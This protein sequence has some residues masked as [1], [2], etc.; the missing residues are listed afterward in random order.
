MPK[1]R[2]SGQEWALDLFIAALGIDALMP[3][4]SKLQAS[5]VYGMNNADV[6]R[7]VKRTKGLLGMRE[8]YLRVAR[9][10]EAI[11]CEAEGAG[12]RA[13]ARRHFHQAALAYGMAQYTIQ[14]DF[15]KLKAELHAKSQECYLKAAS[16]ADTPVEK[17]EIPFRDN[18]PF[19]G[20]SFPGIL[21]LPGGEGPFPCVIFIPGTDMHKE[22]IPNLEDNLFLKRGLACLSIDGPGQGES[23]L[24][25]L[26][27]N[28]LTNNYERAVSAAIDY[29][30]GRGEIDARHIA[31]LGVSTGSYWEASAAVWESRRKG[32]IKAAVGLMP[33]WNPGFEI[34]MKY[35]QPN[36]KSNY[37]FM[38]GFKDEDEFDRHL[39]VHDLTD[40]IADVKCPLLLCQG[41]F[42]YWG[43]STEELLALM[44]KSSVP[45][46]LRVYKGEHHTLGGVA[47]E[48]WEEA[49]DWIVDRFAGRPVQPD[50]LRI[51]PEP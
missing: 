5:P 9:R 12:H 22:M 27:V 3:D 38:A 14:E 37:M 48:A 34:E 20:E 51:Y 2:R 46:E 30:E 6:E 25:M 42:D 8:E 33:Q 19:E 45:H 31:V 21:H 24:R 36:F 17:V 11:A 18:P 32:R 43:G 29:L 50:A 13:T 16:Y 35:L 26:K 10:R 47:V 44:R 28:G 15:N 39:A 49:I 1:I 41:E 40:A 7:V 23:L 4:F